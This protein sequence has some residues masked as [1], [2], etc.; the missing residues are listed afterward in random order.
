MI[1]D[2]DSDTSLKRLNSRNLIQDEYD[3]MKKEQHD[4]I[5][6]GFQNIA[7]IFSFRSILINASNNEQIIFSKIIKAI[8]KKFTCSL[9]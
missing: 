8:E 7:K 3:A 6:K 4:I 2:V 9:Q 5:R 1:L